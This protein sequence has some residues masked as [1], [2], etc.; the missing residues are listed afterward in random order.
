M[1]ETTFRRFDAAEILETEED[2]AVYL[3]DSNESG[4]PA[5]MLNALGT[6]ARARNM[7]AIADAANMSR[8]GLY[9]ALSPAGNPSFTM[10]DKI[11][12]AMGFQV[13]L[14]PVKAKVKT[15]TVKRPRVR[16]A[17]PASK[18]VATKRPVRAAA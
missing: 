5:A 12:K 1:V 14:V 16:K 13:S 18:R 8:S 10:V 9:K 2:V 11:A 4:D 3:Q 7:K 15:K 17:A 6:V